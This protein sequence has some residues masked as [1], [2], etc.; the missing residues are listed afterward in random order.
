MSSS[1][2]RLSGRLRQS[3]NEPWRENPRPCSVSRRS[4]FR[5]S[6]GRLRSLR[7]RFQRRA[8][9][10]RRRRCCWCLSCWAALPGLSLAPSANM[11]GKR[12]PN[13]QW[14]TGL[15]QPPR[16]QVPIQQEGRKRHHRV[17]S[18]RQPFAPQYRRL[19]LRSPSPRGWRRRGKWAARFI[20]L[21]RD[22]MERL[23]QGRWSSSVMW[24]NLR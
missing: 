9:P 15:T 10:V 14:L 1:P 8:V 13:P 7:G 22:R 24:S 3:G 23:K 11:P 20:F 5:R 21:V 6:P 12:V 18:L 19:P 16:R 4:E 17:F 2:R